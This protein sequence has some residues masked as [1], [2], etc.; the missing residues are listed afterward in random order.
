M[1]RAGAV[2]GP[3][4]GRYL[5]PPGGLG[6]NLSD[7]PR[8][9]LCALRRYA[10]RFAE[11]IHQVLPGKLLA[12]NCLPS[13]HWKRTLDDATIPKFQ[14]ELG[15]MGYKFQYVTLAGSYALNLSMFDLAREYAETGLGP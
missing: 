3:A 9:G 8:T 10:R 6:I 12:Y 1:H 13:F 11:A 15:A 7:R 14:E 2:M 5:A 4:A